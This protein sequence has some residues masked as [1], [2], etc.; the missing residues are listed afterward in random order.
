MPLKSKNLGASQL[1]SVV[2]DLLL[3]ELQQNSTNLRIVGQTDIEAV[4]GLEKRKD[5]LGCDS[6]ACLAEIG[7][8][9]GVESII[10]G[11]VSRL[12]KAH[13]LSL[14]WVRQRDASVIARISESLG[15]KEDGFPPLV[16]RTV[17][18]LL[19]IAPDVKAG[20]KDDT[21]PEVRGAAV[22]GVPIQVGAGGIEQFDQWEVLNGVWYANDGAFYGSNGHLMWKGTTPKNYKF[23]V[24]SEQVSGPVGSSHGVGVR[25][26]VIPGKNLRNGT[27]DLQCY[28]FNFSGNLTWSV[29]RG[30]GGSWFRVNP[31]EW[32]K[33]SLLKNGPNRIEWTVRGSEYVVSANGSEVFRFQDG[34]LPFGPPLVAVHFANATF[35]FSDLRLTPLD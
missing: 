6:A 16:H 18:T 27:A 28:G 22:S 29:F 26:I 12:G 14:S 19:G 30:S 20:G 5:A 34:S 10:Y 1:S 23:A 15:E 13:M 25:T 21:K 24:T 32:P 2:D 9:L 33:S 11:A 7:G 8:A 31:T 17:L 4:I 3:S 35:K